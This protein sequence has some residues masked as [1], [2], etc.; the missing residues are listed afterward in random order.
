LNSIGRA[1]VAARAPPAALSP[2]HH[3]AYLQGHGIL[4]VGPGRTKEERNAFLFHDLG[5]S[6]ADFTDVFMVPF[7]SRAVLSFGRFVQGSYC[8][9]PFRAW[10]VLCLGLFVMGCFFICI[11]STTRRRTAMSLNAFTDQH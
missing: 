1:A 9:G 4:S 6:V 7:T 2:R 8:F 3:I 11:S 10:A 5:L